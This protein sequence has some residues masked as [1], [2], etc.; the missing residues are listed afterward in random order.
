[1]QM[2][3]KKMQLELTDQNVI[4]FVTKTVHTFKLQSEEKNIGL[5]LDIEVQS[6][7]E[8][9]IS[10]DHELVSNHNTIF[11]D[12][13]KMQQVVNNLISNALKF[14]EEG[15]TVTVKLRKSSELLPLKE[16]VTS[17]TLR[18]VSPQT[19]RSSITETLRYISGF[20]HTQRSNDSIA[21]SNAESDIENNQVP[22]VPENHERKCIG[23][24]ILSVIDGGVGM[25]PED[26]QQLFKDIVQFNPGKL[27][28]G[29]GSG[30]GMMITK[31]I[32]D[33]HGGEISVFSDG[34]GCGSTFI[35]KLP[36]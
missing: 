21:V 34:I 24:L 18:D 25:K 22:H 23:T 36:L 4:D 19:R 10:Y 3:E 11:V 8:S 28:A 14:T 20:L 6:E 9:T 32:V 15:K 30:L 29:G 27:Q 26:L 13:T 17:Q 2:D 5:N 12:A 16:N 33:L 7:A 1:M 31:G 35:V